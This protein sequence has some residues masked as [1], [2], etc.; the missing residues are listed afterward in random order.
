MVPYGIG[1]QGWKLENCVQVFLKYFFFICVHGYI[2]IDGKNWTLEKRK[3]RSR[4][5][6]PTC[7]ELL[8]FQKKIKFLFDRD[9]S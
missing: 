4:F 5:N 6:S 3:K 8:V 9:K 7:K 1:V 2:E